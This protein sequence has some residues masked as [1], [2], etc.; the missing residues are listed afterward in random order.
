MER[1]RGPAHAVHGA[2]EYTQLLTLVYKPRSLGGSYS[3]PVLCRARGLGRLVGQRG[4]EGGEPLPVVRE[5]VLL[6]LVRAGLG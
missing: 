4:R 5:H 1:T 6:H 2:H 3:A